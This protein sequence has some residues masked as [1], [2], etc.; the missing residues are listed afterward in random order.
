LEPQEIVVIP[1]GLRFRVELLEARRAAIFVRISGRPA[2]AGLGPIGS[3]GLANPR[4]F[5][6]PVAW[7]EDSSG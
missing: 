5:Q 7:Y 4:D 1:R 2:A 3:N 6:T